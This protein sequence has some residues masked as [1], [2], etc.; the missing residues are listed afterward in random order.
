MSAEQPEDTHND[1]ADAD[2]S[3]DDGPGLNE[4]GAVYS[5]FQS[6]Q[7]GAQHLRCDVLAA[8]G[9]LADGV[10]QY[11]GLRTLNTGLGQLPGD[12]SESNIRATKPPLLSP[13]RSLDGSSG[14]CG[15]DATPGPHD[16]PPAPRIPEPSI[17]RR[18][19]VFVRSSA[20]APLS[21]FG[22]P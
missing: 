14:G 2:Q 5:G 16:W 15:R 11:V 1:A 9:G 19:G 13:R 8:V 3:A 6:G 17:P 7:F 12:V 4:H 21:E 10:R 22:R 20:R 18:Q